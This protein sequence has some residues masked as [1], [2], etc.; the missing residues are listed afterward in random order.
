VTEGAFSRRRGASCPRLREIVSEQRRKLLPEREY[1]PDPWR[2]VERRFMPGFLPQTETLFCTS[3]GYLG[4]RATPEEGAPV[5]ERGTYL[6]G[7][8]ETWPFPHAEEAHG[9]PRTGQTM[10]VVPDGTLL[11]LYVDD[12]PFELA[13]AQLLAFERVLDFRSGT[14]AREAHFETPDGRRLC[15]RSQRFASLDHRHLA[16]ID[17]EVRMTRGAA[18]LVISSELVVPAEQPRSEPGDPRRSGGP[19]GQPLV[20]THRRARGQRILMNLETRASGLRMAC[21]MD[22][23]LEAECPVEVEEAECAPDRG[24]VVFHAQVAEGQRVRICKFLAYHHSASADAGELRFRTHRTLDRAL[25][26]GLEDVLAR[27]V[28]R[29]ESFWRAADVEVEG[30]VEVQQALRFNLFQILQACAR[31]EGFGVPAKG[32]SGLGYQGHYFWDTEIYVLPL[33]T[34]TLPHVA[35]S[36]LRL[37]QHQ[38]PL[39]RDRAREVGEQGALFAWRTINGEEASAYYAASTAQY[40]I[41]A[42]VTYAANR[43]V[44]LTGDVEFLCDGL[45][46]IAVETARMWVGLGFYSERKGG[47]FCINGVTGPDEYNT[48]VNNNGYTNLMAREN[49]RIAVR[50]VEMV[51]ERAPEAFAKLVEQTRLDPAELEGWKRAAEHMYVPYDEK[52]GV[53]LQDDGFLDREIWDVERLPAEGYPLLLHYHPLVI[54]RHQLIKQ[55]D[56]VLAAFLLPEAF[57]MEEKRRIFDYY[58]PLTTGDSSLSGCIQSI[59]AEELD[60][61]DQAYRYF[62]DALVMDLGD[63]GGNVRDGLH[64][65]ALAGTWMAVVHGFAGLR[66]QRGELHFRPRLPDGWD[67]LRFRLG[68]RGCV[69]EVDVSREAAR[70]RL[71]EGD[72]LD[73]VHEGELLQLERDCTLTRALRAERAAG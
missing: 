55:A 44:A 33:L 4:I 14:L 39:A 71:L 18:S 35:R 47:R 6:N 11:K 10:L 52:A 19:D 37:R 63:I 24:R 22:H 70:Y 8:Y 72:A 32:L 67:R 40:H 17:Y 16:C 49:L 65:A 36:L 29:V 57:T 61:C 42:D 56:L 46:E 48:V 28:G 13:S 51:Q 30:D 64:V 68:V 31:V 3:N 41:D 60:Y 21:A 1:P 45:A 58:D 15:I 38:L 27:H 73:L 53:H 5:H 54:Y 34:Y 59:V 43:Y 69:L 62:A 25:R 66:E 12:E 9:L 2:L 26:D 50:V 20:P 23:R 7:F